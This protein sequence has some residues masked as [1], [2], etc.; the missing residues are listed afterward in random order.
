MLDALASRE[1]ASTSLGTLWHK[2]SV[3]DSRAGLEIPYRSSYVPAFN[4]RR[5]IP[6]LAWP[7]AP[8]LVRDLRAWKCRYG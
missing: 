7:C 1:P 6:V 4:H 5:L 3:D 8:N 2:Q